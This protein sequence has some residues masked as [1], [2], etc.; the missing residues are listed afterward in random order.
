[1]GSFAADRRFVS[2]P[3]PLPGAGAAAERLFE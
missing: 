2:I 1:M 3:F